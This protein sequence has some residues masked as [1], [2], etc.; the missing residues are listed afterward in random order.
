MFIAIPD[1]SA[2]TACKHYDPSRLRCAQARVIGV[3]ERA[4]QSMSAP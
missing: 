2:C 1:G 4:C 3:A